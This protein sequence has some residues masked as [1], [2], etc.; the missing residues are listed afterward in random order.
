[1]RD[2]KAG[3]DAQTQADNPFHVIVFAAFFIGER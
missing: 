3:E 1:M 2:C